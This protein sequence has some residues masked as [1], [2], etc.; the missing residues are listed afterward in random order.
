[1]DEATAALDNETER[2]FMSALENFSGKKTIIL[3][4][5][6]LTTVKNV[7]QIFFLQNSRLLSSGSYQSLKENCVEFEKMD[8]TWKTADS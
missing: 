7:D 5:H 3:I 1:M 8:Q 6:R 2:A 4:A